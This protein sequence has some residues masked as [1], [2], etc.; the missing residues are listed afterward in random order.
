MEISTIIECVLIILV[1]GMYFGMPFIA[2]EFE[3]LDRRIKAIK[4][5]NII[6]LTFT[7]GLIG[8]ILYEFCGSDFILSGEFKATRVCLIV[9]SI[10][11]FCYNYFFE[12]EKLEEI[13]TKTL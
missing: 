2:R 11:M 7:I 5:M 10:I 6:Y 8:Y 4:V 9:V 3:N 1:F 12:T 13:T